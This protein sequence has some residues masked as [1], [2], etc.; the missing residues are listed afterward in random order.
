[1]SIEDKIRELELELQKLKGKGNEAKDKKVYYQVPVEGI[2]YQGRKTISNILYTTDKF[3]PGE[4]KRRMFHFN[5]E[6]K[7][8]G[9]TEYK[10]MIIDGGWFESSW[11]AKAEKDKSA[12][13]N[14][15]VKKEDVLGMLQ[16]NEAQEQLAA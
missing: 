2:S 8:V 11:E 1:M 5:G 4:I 3:E 7:V 12:K 9:H 14:S 10:Q 13:K 6:S 16:P 15:K